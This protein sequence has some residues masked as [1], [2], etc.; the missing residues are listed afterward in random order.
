MKQLAIVCTILAAF[1]CGLFF[2]GTFPREARTYD[3]MQPTTTHSVLCMG[4]YGETV[5]YHIFMPSFEG[6]TDVEVTDLKESY[7]Q[8][9]CDSIR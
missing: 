1:L 6:F 4:D 2:Y 9:F 7:A 8:G 5:T 3:N